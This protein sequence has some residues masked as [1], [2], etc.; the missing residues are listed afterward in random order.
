MHVLEP[1]VPVLC[2]LLVTAGDEEVLVD[3][4]WAMSYLAEDFVYLEVVCKPEAVAAVV[5]LLDHPSTG[6]RC[7][8]MLPTCLNPPRPPGRWRLTVIN[9]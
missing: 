4:C 1:L 3:A 8:P 7:V 2:Q 6:V 9:P 5:N